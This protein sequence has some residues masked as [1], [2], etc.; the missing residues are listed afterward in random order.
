[1]DKQ[2]W[3][4]QFRLGFASRLADHGVTPSEAE[5]MLKEGK[6]AD[7]LVKGL[8]DLG[9]KGGKMMAVGL[10]MFLGANLGWHMGAGVRPNKDD[11]AYLK[12]LA[13]LREYEDAVA[14]LRNRQPKQEREE[15]QV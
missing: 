14:Q 15:A 2:T 9:T 10:P 1:M 11:I 8:L 4:E 6:V 12:Q 7:T 3:R 13:L 5:A